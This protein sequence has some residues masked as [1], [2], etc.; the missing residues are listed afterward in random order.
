M[1][2]LRDHW[3]PLKAK[4]EAGLGKARRELAEHEASRMPDILLLMDRVSIFESEWLVRKGAAAV[5]YAE[6][7]LQNDLPPTTAFQNV[8]W[9]GL[10]N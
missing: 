10:D 9:D 1:V 3:R 2:E 4:Y 6:C 5:A 8:S 7:V